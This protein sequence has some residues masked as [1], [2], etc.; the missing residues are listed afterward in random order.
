MIMIRR[1]AAATQ[2]RPPPAIV[3][4]MPVPGWLR[5]GVA[6]PA[7]PAAQ[8]VSAG[9]PEDAALLAGAAIGVLDALVR[10]DEPWAGAWRQRLAL[11]A[12]AATAR[13]AGRAED[14][15]ALRDAVLLTRAGD[16][17]G[18]GGAFV[19]A[20]RR[21]TGRPA[22][23]LAREECLA[24]MLQEFGF[25]RDPE[26]AA[27][28]ADELGRL[29]RSEGAVQMLTGAFALAD[30]FRLPRFVGAWLADALLARR[31]GW[32]HALPLLG[33]EMPAGDGR[34]RRGSAVEEASPDE[35]PA[36][37]TR[38]LLAV[39]ARAALRAIDL[40]TELSR[41]AERLVAIVPKLRAKGA[42]AIVERLLNEDALVASRGPTNG[43]S[44]RALR[45]LFDR[46]VS[47]S[48]VRELTGR[49]AF[50]IYGL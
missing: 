44:D 6:E 24:A 7:S 20:W 27:D 42:D 47:S 25:P 23:D 4:S 3:A 49:P 32:A 41:R 48:A 22:A 35:T 21:L 14:E 29:G 1:A 19:L 37:R 8:R 10:R 9:A 28:L 2:D 45:R 12:A 38:T 39:Q 18:P 16:D 36:E 46:L 30:R 15:A 5:G 40:S 31:L 11:T 43:M 13:Q 17:P 33:A 50:R 26:T 34:R